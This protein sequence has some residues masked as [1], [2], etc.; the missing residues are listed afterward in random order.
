ML[1]VLISDP[2]ID[3]Y[4]KEKEV[5]FLNTV[6]YSTDLHVLD[7]S[8]S[9]LNCQF[10]QVLPSGL[11]RSPNCNSDFLFELKIISASLYI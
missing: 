10:C 3:I 11:S 7:L 6:K 9:A 2:Q 8:L 1:M 4:S 5:L